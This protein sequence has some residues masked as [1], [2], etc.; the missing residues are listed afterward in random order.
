MGGGLSVELGELRDVLP[1]P[2]PPPPPPAAQKKPFDWRVLH[3]IEEGQ[4]VES[5]VDF[6]L[7]GKWT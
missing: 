1:T 3:P 2:P 6:E 7:E 5:L 4:G